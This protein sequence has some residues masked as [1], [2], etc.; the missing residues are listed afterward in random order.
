MKTNDEK[1]T[2]K[3]KRNAIAKAKKYAKARGT[4]LSRLVEGYFFKIAEP[5]PELLE[6][7]L[8]PIV[9]ELSGVIKP[10]SDKQVKEDYEQYL[11]RKYGL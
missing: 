5:S 4:S 7:D 10:I 9:K 1:L 2:L 6:E 11:K 8:S 3:L